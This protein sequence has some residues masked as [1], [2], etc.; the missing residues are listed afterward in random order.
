MAVRHLVLNSTCEISSVTSSHLTLQQ[1]NA[2]ARR[3]ALGRGGAREAPRRAATRCGGAA[4]P[5]GPQ[6]VAARCKRR[7]ARAQPFQTR[8]AAV[9][10]QRTATRSATK[11]SEKRKATQCRHSRATVSS[12]SFKSIG[13]QSD[14]SRVTVGS[15]F[16]LKHF[17]SSLS[18]IS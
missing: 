11:S 1:H 16:W 2:I 15:P 8:A 10:P 12:H 18:G 7:A 6:R 9:A 3:V 14:H 4:A 17:G 13:S 5:A